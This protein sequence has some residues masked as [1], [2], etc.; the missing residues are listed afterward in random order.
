VATLSP[1]PLG[2]ADESRLRELDA[3]VGSECQLRGIV[4]PNLEHQ[5][6]DRRLVPFGFTRVP[7][8]QS[9][10]G[11]LIPMPGSNWHQ[12]MR[13]LKQIV[14]QTISRATIR[15]DDA[16]PDSAEKSEKRAY[17]RSMSRAAADCARRFKAAKKSDPTTKMRHVVEEYVDKHGGSVASI[18]RT[19]ND[20]PEQWKPGN[21]R[22]AM[23]A[24]VYFKFR[25][26]PQLPRRKSLRS[27]LSI[28]TTTTGLS[29]L[30]VKGWDA[31]GGWGEA[32]DGWGVACL[33]IFLSLFRN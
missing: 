10:D 27:Q 4:I 3:M 15:A 23:N 2:Q 1:K 33:G 30:T 17:R 21:S 11:K 13:G 9:V 20:N 6:E 7:C 12:A 29:L 31:T 14:L 22:S 18:M 24:A 5:I 25:H 28:N 8:R 16:Q 32:T 26:Y 19:L